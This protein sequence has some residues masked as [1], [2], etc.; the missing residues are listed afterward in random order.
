MQL[1]VLNPGGRDAEQRFPEGAGA[2]DAHAHP[3]VN[4]HAYA[5]CTRGGFFRDTRAIPPEMR[6]VLLLLRSDLK[7]GLSAL[8]ALR[9]QGKVI[10]I[11]WKESGQHQV[12]EQLDS[13]PNLAAFREICA[14]ADG[15]L[16]ST[17]ELVPL[18]RAAGAR[19]AEFIPTPYPVEDRHWDFSRPLA[20]REGI[21]IGTREWNVP[22]RNHAAALLRACATGAPVTVFNVDGRA[23][24]KKLDALG[25]PRLKA[26]EGRLPYPDYLREM[27]KCR[28]VFQLDASAVPGQVA[29]D[30]LL[31]RMPC[32]GGNG[33]V[34]R[35][36]FTSDDPALLLHDN[37]AW[38][39]AVGASQQR[40]TE[41]L[42]FAAGA[43]RLRKF[44]AGIG[45]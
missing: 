6:A 25:C 43:E 4:Y 16:S 17:P 5:A 27:A 2:P 34:D 1:A 22:S 37:P 7:A 30:A 39:A 44:F 23:G 40:A 41:Q 29:G 15:A 14:L 45:L 32:V 11:S 36:A 28:V 42:G 20:E 35:T 26:I 8:K 3:P 21:F 9:A 33:A 18:Y 38:I 12:A 24:R 31:C 13:A 10:A 19:T